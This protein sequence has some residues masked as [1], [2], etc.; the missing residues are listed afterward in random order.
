MQGYKDLRVY[1]KSYRAAKA[2]YQLSEEFPKEEIL[3]DNK[4]DKTSK[5]VNTAE[6]SGRICQ[7]RKPKRVQKVFRDG[8]RL[9]Q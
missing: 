2:I 8:N 5:P 1:E 6:H 7:T 4:S 9:K 3:C